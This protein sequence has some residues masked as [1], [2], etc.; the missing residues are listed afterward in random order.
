MSLATLDIPSR[1]MLN[2][3]LII[4]FANNCFLNLPDTLVTDLGEKGPRSETGK[5][6][7]KK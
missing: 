5:R 4:N 2:L 7:A 1:S 6:S 3:S